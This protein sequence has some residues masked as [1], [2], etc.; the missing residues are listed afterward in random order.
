MIIIAAAAVALV[1]YPL[2]ARGPSS[3]RARGASNSNENSL[4]ELLR[5]KQA[6]YDE[7]KE[8]DFDFKMGKISEGDYEQMMQAHRA[9]AVEILKAIEGAS[10]KEDFDKD[11]EARVMDLRKS[12]RGAKKAPAATTCHNCGQR[13]GSGE[14]FCPACGS[15]MAS[16]CP[17]CG[18]ETAEGDNFCRGCGA[19]L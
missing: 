13:L 1:G 18:A 10:G 15:R 7:L 16:I 12:S 14:K 6:V 2:F 19:K 11:I 3:R 9:E 5:K 17:G 4:S 8:I